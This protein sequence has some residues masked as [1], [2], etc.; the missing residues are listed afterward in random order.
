MGVNISGSGILSG[1]GSLVMGA[2]NS[3][4]LLVTRIIGYTTSSGGGSSYYTTMVGSTG[5]GYVL[6]KNDGIYYSTDLENLSTTKTLDTWGIDEILEVNGRF[7]TKGQQ[8]PQTSSDG[9]NWNSIAAFQNVADRRE[10]DRFSLQGAFYVNNE[11]YLVGNTYSGEGTQ[12][13]PY[14]Y[15]GMIFRSTDG[16]IWDFLSYGTDH[17]F[18]YPQHLDH[19]VLA[20]VG[21]GSGSKTI[22]FTTDLY[23]WNNLE[24]SIYDDQNSEYISYTGPIPNRLTRTGVKVIAHSTSSELQSG[25]W[26]GEMNEWTLVDRMEFRNPGTDYVGLSSISYHANGQFYFGI[27]ASSPGTIFTANGASGLIGNWVETDLPSPLDVVTFQET[28]FLNGL[29]IIYGNFGILVITRDPNTGLV[30]TDLSNIFDD[31]TGNPPYVGE[32]IYDN[33][34]WIAVAYSG[35]VAGTS[36]FNLQ[37]KNNTQGFFNITAGTVSTLVEAQVSIGDQGTEGAEILAP[38]DVYTVPPGKTTFIDQVTLKN[39]SSNTITYDLDVLDPGVELTDENLIRNDQEI[40][41][42]ATATVTTPAFE[43]LTAGQRVVVLPSA[44]DVVEVKVY[45]TETSV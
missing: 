37:Y 16:I 20:I 23:S 30:T 1:I 10:I 8:S 44:V 3:L 12:E 28:K 18:F 22:K 14:E 9:V 40:L 19:R 26:V 31:F 7:F 36:I 33:G 35:I 2:V 41:A 25:E 27:D 21:S 11:Y 39:N 32:V 29:P 34:K 38:V 13:S 5:P 45:G 42:G 43:N 15:Y 17:L 4:N 24:L 6:A